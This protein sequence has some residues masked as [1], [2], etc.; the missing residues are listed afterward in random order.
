MTDEIQRMN[1]F[2]AMFPNA[3]QST[4]AAN[5]HLVASATVSPKTKTNDVQPVLKRKR[6]KMTGVEKEFGL[7]LEAQKRRG[8]ILRYEFQGMTLRWGVDEKTGDSMKY[9]PDWVVFG[10]PETQDSN[11]EPFVRIL[12][13][14]NLIEVKD[15]HIHYR[16]QA[17]ARFKGCRSWWPEFSFE[18]WQRQKTGWIRLF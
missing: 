9:T 18:M 15:S 13:G 7:M 10:F 2:K 16:Q 6:G 5:P 4:V 3:S 12:Y 8:E 17:I 1:A 14:I 11:T